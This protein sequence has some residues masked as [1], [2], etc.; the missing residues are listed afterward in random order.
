MTGIAAEARSVSRRFVGRRAQAVTALDSVSLRIESAEFAAL[1]GRSGSGKTT[2]LSLF[3]GLDRPTDGSILLDGEDLRT[4]SRARHTRITRDA[5]YV[6]QEAAVIRRMPV[7]ENV[8]CGLVPLGIPSAERLDLAEEVLE[9]VGLS[10][11]SWRRPGELSGGERQRMSL[12]RALV[13]Q[14]RLLLADEPTSNLDSESAAIVCDVLASLP[15]Q[16]CTVIVATHDDALLGRAERVIRMKHG[17][18]V[19]PG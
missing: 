2:L 4:V 7:W 12:A 19:D 16:G 6:F 15:R 11:L 13:H 5:G 10:G 14:P 1:S 17:R 8:S 18:L 9:R 3:G